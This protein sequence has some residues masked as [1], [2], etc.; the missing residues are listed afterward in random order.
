VTESHSSVTTGNP[1]S[2]EN[3]ESQK[4][5]NNLYKRINELEVANDS[6]RLKVVSVKPVNMAALSQWN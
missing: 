2:T 4:K 6:L 5:I 1:P 3:E